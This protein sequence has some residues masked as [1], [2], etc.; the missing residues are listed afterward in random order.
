[1]SLCYDSKKWLMITLVLVALTLTIG[2]IG[3]AYGLDEDYPPFDDNKTPEFCKILKYSNLTESA[4]DC[5][6]R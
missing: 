6:K 4:P 1:M 5:T 2:L 3:L